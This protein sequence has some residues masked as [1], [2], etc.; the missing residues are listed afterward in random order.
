MATSSRP[1]VGK[2]RSSPGP[3]R[4]AFG[5]GDGVRSAR[6]MEASME[7]VVQSADGRALAVTESGDL[8]GYPVLVHMGTPNSRWLYGR[9]IRDAAERGLRLISYDRPG[10]GGSAAQ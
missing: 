6:V 8:D 3:G 10:Y 5:A 9:N 4:V 1:L 7:R 2:S